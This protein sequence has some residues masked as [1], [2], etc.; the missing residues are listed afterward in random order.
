M[1]SSTARGGGV[2]EML[3]RVI[4]LLQDLGLQARW[5]VIG[6]DRRSSSG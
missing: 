4:K 2:A 1:V 3:P 6:S 5:A